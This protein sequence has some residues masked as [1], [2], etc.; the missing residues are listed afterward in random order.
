VCATQKL[1]IDAIPSAL[2]ANLDSAVF[3]R[4]SRQMAA[5][6]F[7]GDAGLQFDPPRLRRGQAAAFID[8]ETRFFQ[9]FMTDPSEG[10][11]HAA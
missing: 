11:K 4:T 5:S 2:R 6:V 3:F 9:A 10:N 8:G 7:G 1:T